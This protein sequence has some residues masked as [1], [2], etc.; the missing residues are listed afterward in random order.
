MNF[1]MT[2]AG[3]SFD[4]AN[5]RIHSFGDPVAGTTDYVFCLYDEGQAQ[6]SLVLHSEVRAGGD[7]DGDACWKREQGDKGFRYSDSEG[8]SDGVVSLSLKTGGSGNPVIQWK[9]R[10][11][12]SETSGVAA[13]GGPGRDGP[14]PQ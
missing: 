12:E 4:L 11:G 6:P 8:L 7:C 14:D 2:V 5:P 1:A 9:A 3:D 10:G 13:L